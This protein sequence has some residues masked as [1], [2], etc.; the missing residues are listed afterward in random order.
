MLFEICNIFFLIAL[1]TILRKQ[2]YIMIYYVSLFS[3]HFRKL[4][5]RTLVCAY[6]FLVF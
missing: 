2:T 6:S 3:F 1:E 5:I 4:R